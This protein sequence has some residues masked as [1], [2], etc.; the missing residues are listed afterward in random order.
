M[1]KKRSNNK[2]NLMRTSSWLIPRNNQILWN[3][4]PDTILVPQIIIKPSDSIDGW[5]SNN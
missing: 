2:Q 1:I 4:F 3:R 5:Y